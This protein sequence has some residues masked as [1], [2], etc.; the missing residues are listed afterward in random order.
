MIAKTMDAMGLD[1]GN[2]GEGGRGVAKKG[3]GER[4]LQPR[5]GISAGNASTGR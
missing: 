5:K 4:E 3:E 1:E 2:G